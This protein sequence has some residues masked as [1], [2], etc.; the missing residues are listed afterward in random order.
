MKV[1]DLC[2][3]LDELSDEEKNAELLPIGVQQLNVLI[4]LG[5]H[6]QAEKLASGITLA[7]YAKVVNANW[8]FTDC[9]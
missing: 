4:R 7:E 9:K 3:T 6:E 2:K 8:M 5:K 1:V